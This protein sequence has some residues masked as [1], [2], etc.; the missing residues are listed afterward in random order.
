MKALRFIVVSGMCL[1]SSLVVNAQD[2]VETS[3]SVDIVSQYVW[4]GMDLGS[5]SIQPGLGISYKGL[6]LSAWGSVG[7]T[8]ADDTKEFDLTLA[9]SAGGFNIGITDYWFDSGLDPKN[10]YFRY[11][12]HSTN[13]LFEGNVGYDFGC[14]SLQWY[15]NL[16]GNDGLNKDGDRAYSSYIEM[17]V[18]FSC[19]SCDWEAV[20]G[21]VPYATDFYGTNGFAVTEIGLKATKEFSI[22]EKV[23]VPV[24]MGI[25]ANPCSQNCHFYAGV[26]FQL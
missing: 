7:L 24:Y 12:A 4:R 2:K 5:S 19:V 9:Y 11:N 26:A 18:P 20:L 16:L 13:H 1:C 15:T 3:M 10:R 22:G 6:S 8:S 14:L 21:A 25:S 23:T 17:A